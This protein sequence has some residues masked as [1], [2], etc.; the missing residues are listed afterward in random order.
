MRVNLNQ[1]RGHLKRD[2]ALTYL[3]CG[4]E[5]LLV[6]EGCTLIREVAQERGFNERRVITVEPGFDWA[7]FFSLT[8]SPSL[9]SPRRLI[10]NAPGYE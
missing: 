3:V 10:G 2:L 5:P 1:L 7:S 9:F 8:C 4:E 6:D